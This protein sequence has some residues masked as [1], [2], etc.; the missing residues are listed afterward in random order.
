MR[1]I[2]SYFELPLLLAISGV[3]FLLERSATHLQDPFSNLPTDTAMTTIARNIEINI[4]Q[5][6]NESNIP[7]PIP[8]QKFYLL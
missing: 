5:L 4:R 7:Q 1:N 2:E 3:F 8:A 6:L